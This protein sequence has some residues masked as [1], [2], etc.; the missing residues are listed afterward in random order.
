MFVQASYN[1]LIA[2]PHAMAH[3]LQLRLRPAGQ[4]TAHELDWRLVIG[5]ASSSSISKCQDAPQYSCCRVRR[6]LVDVY[7]A[8]VGAAHAHR[9]RGCR[10]SRLC[11]HIQQEDVSEHGLILSC[12]HALWKFDWIRRSKNV[13]QD[14]CKPSGQLGAAH[15]FNARLILTP[16]V[17]LAARNPTIN[18]PAHCLQVFFLEQFKPSFSSRYP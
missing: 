10:H 1:N 4:D 12:S 14:S 17:Y 15:G 16:H 5:V 7:R 2:L 6:L 18:D 11:G 9:P 13:Y 8:G 3:S